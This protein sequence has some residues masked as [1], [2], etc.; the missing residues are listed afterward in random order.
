[1][2]YSENSIAY[3]IYNYEAHCTA[4]CSSS[5]TADSLKHLHARVIAKNKVATFFII[6]KKKSEVQ[7]S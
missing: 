6:I 1:M 2:N 4:S 5:K 3:F 7:F